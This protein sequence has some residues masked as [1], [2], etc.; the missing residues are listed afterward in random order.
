MEHLSLQLPDI[1]GVGIK[2]TP[3]GGSD[4]EA[5]A[6][7][8]VGCRD[9]ERPWQGRPSNRLDS[10]AIPEQDCRLEHITATDQTNSRIIHHSTQEYMEARR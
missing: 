7:G 5:N 4:V 9:Q 10:A 6:D 3:R 8:D 1:Y 2:L